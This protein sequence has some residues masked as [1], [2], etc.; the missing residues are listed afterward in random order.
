MATEKTTAPKTDVA[1][2]AS[3]SVYSAEELAK[4]Y[5]VFGTSYEIVAVALR[6]AGKT[7]ATV[8][9]AQKIIDKFKSKEVK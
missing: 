8:T 4:N 2:Q 1:V 7:A 6:L 5:K 9:E 3:E